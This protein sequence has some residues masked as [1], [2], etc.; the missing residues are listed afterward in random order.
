MYKTFDFSSKFDFLKMH[1]IFCQLHCI[2]AD[3]HVK[4][5]K[6]NNKM[7]I[8]VGLALISSHCTWVYIVD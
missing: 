4:W 5:Y 3:S 8:T 6:A 1:F 2:E 7:V